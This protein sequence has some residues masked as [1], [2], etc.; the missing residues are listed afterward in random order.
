MLK[1]SII[2]VFAFVFVLS[3]SEVYAQKTITLSPN[4]SKQLTNSAL[5][6]LN[7]TCS[8][9]GSASGSRIRVSVLAN[10]G[11]V[12]GRQLAK[13]QATSVNVKNH[14]NISV[15]AEPGT[16]VNLVNLSGSSVQAVCNT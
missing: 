13:G 10:K 12:N 8:I 4:E 9:Q 16:T 11:S 7:A 2:A 14:A 15:S 1:T 5:W 6:T 3:T